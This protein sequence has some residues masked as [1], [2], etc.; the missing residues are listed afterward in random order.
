MVIGAAACRVAALF[1]YS[2]MANVVL[3]DTDFVSGNQAYEQYALIYSKGMAE[4]FG[5]DYSKEE[6]NLDRFVK[7]V[8]GEKVVYRKCSARRGVRSDEVALGSRT[9]KEL[10]CDIGSNVNVSK[11]SWAQYYWHNSDTYIKFMFILA[12]LGAICSI[13]SFVSGLVCHC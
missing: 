5:E 8:N 1:G 7:I 12:I 10:G 4:L 13:V 9:R 11:A 6:M 2:I 3:Q